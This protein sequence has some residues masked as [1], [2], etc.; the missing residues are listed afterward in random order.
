MPQIPY[1]YIW[2]FLYADTSDFASASSQYKLQHFVIPVI[3]TSFS[4]HIIANNYKTNKNWGFSS[5]LRLIS[6][7]SVILYFL[8]LQNI[9]IFHTHYFY[10]NYFCTLYFLHRYYIFLRSFFSNPI[11]CNVYVYT[12][13]FLYT[14]FFF[15]WLGKKCK[16]AQML[17][18]KSTKSHWTPF[19]K[20]QNNSKVWRWNYRRDYFPFASQCRVWSNVTA[21]FSASS[22]QNQFGKNHGRHRFGGMK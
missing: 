17:Y 8:Y 3:K 14:L 4:F 16:N 10:C 2:W 11:L 6:L 15:F 19:A 1:K 22:A 18:K 21:N 20:C 7:G 9:L 12:P 5:Y 13:L